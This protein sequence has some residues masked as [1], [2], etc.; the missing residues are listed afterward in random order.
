MTRKFN[1]PKFSIIG[2]GYIAQKHKHAI[3]KN[4]GII[5]HIYDPLK[6]DTK[7]TPEFFSDY[8]VICSPSHLH[9]Q[10]IQMAM[11][12]STTSK[13]IVEK[14]MVLPWEPIIDDDR[15]NI[16]LQLRWIENLPQEADLVKCTMI[17]DEDYFKRARNATETGGV[18]YQL[19]IHYIDLAIRLNAKFEGVVY[20][21]GDQIRTIDNIDIMKID[22]N[23]LYTRMYND[24]INHDKGVKPSDLFYIHWILERIGW[25]YGLYN[26]NVYDK[27]FILN[28][29]KG[30][31][32]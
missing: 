18:L 4:G 17:R 5:K 15:I 26:Q 21:Q 31:T 11:R 6:Y 27:K 28:F 8:V 16:V 23:D 14:P 30:I 29:K 19:F 1:I 24:I 25:N 13:I 22:M 10:H 20:E 32:I 9:R 12:Y 7:L 3:E 2:D